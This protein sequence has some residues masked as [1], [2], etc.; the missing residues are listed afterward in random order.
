MELLPYPRGLSL[1]MRRCGLN[2][3]TSATSL[4]SVLRRQHVDEFGMCFYF[5]VASTTRQSELMLPMYFYFSL[6]ACDPAFITWLSFGLSLFGPVEFSNTCDILSC[7]SVASLLCWL[8]GFVILAQIEKC[9]QVIHDDRRTG[10]RAV[11]FGCPNLEKR[12]VIS[13]HP[14]LHRALWCAGH[15]AYVNRANSCLSSSS[16]TS[17]IVLCWPSPRTLSSA[18]SLF[19]P[20]TRRV[21]WLSAHS[22]Q[23]DRSCLN[24]ALW[25]QCELSLFDSACSVCSAISCPCLHLFVVCENPFLSSLGPV[26]ES[27]TSNPCWNVYLVHFWR[28]RSDRN[29][30]PTWSRH[31]N[32]SSDI[33]AFYWVQLHWSCHT[34]SGAGCSPVH[35][36]M[37]KVDVSTVYRPRVWKTTLLKSEP[38]LRDPRMMR[39]SWFDLDWFVG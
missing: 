22:E 19:V 2:S 31:A 29:R 36:K 8:C 20:T 27:G 28:L 35:I 4:W 14:A 24:R 18:I 1:S 23:C 21:F 34:G 37:A 10:S 5:H 11:L 32:M 33:E 13:L 12:C 7:V 17:R 39:K 30:I 25:K 9:S 3:I 26:G 15:S 38:W 6:S 16:V